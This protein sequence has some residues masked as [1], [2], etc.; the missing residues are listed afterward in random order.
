MSL[1]LVTSQP[2]VLPRDKVVTVPGEKRFGSFEQ[3]NCAICL[4]GLSRPVEL[5]CGHCFCA[6]TT[7][8]QHRLSHFFPRAKGT[9]VGR[10]A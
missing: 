6:S 4:G 3:D 8:R 10:A 5:A 9:L 7:P 1:G 2:F